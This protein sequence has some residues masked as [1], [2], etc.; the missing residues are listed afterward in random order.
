MLQYFA[1][2]SRERNERMSIIWTALAVIVLW[3]GW[4]HRS[5]ISATRR[6]DTPAIDDAA[7][8]RIIQEGRLRTGEEEALDLEAARE[9]EE[10]FLDEYW[11]EPDEY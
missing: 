11:D 6:G 4:R 8:D 7:I 5:R 9:A 3:A 1:H 10:E 2:S